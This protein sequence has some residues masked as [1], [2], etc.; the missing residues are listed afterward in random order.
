MERRF[1]CTACGKCCYGLLPLTLEDALAHADKFPLAV[2][3]TPVRQGGRSF[4]VTA[5]MG[6]TVPLKKRKLA[7]VQIAP[8]AYIPPT[9]PCPELT[10]EGLCGIQATKPQRCRT[11]PFSAYRDE[12]DQDDLLIPRPGW[13]CDTSET[14]PAVYR[15]RRIL[16]PKDF[17]D[18]RERLVRDAAILRPYGEW[19]LDSQPS[20]RMELQR[21]AMKPSGGRVIVSFATLIPR[22]P[23]VD[24]YDFAA[25]QAPVMRAFAG[26]TAGD[27]GL[28]EYH[29]RYS[30]GAGEWGRIAAQ[31]Q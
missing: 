22:L 10:E 14:A 30:D 1:S 23:K 25:K 24:I 28:A 5:E 3:W 16:E 19:L 9:L 6:I 27:A 4:D 12:S 2:I 7:A 29:R 8:T 31:R 18:E 13:V 26:K 15:D 11:M 21:I 17:D 20:L